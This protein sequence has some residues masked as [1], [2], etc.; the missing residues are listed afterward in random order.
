MHDVV[1]LQP[2]CDKVYVS[3]SDVQMHANY[4]RKTSVIQQQGFQRFRATEDCAD[5]TCPFHLQ[6]TT[7]FHCRRRDC[8]FTSKNKADMEKHKSF[9]QKDD[10]LAKD[11]FRKFMKHDACNFDGCKLSRVANHIHCVRAGAL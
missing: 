6:R 5:A 3:T 1:V 10:L 4:H 11:G 7:H 8:K 2:G 9:H